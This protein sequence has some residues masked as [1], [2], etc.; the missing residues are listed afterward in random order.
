[1]DC[2]LPGFSLHGILQARTLEWVA[3]S[4]SIKLPGRLLL[5]MCCYYVISLALNRYS[6]FSL[7]IAGKMGLPSWLG[8]KESDCQ[9]RGHGSIPGRGR[10]HILR[11]NQALVPQLLRLCSE[12]QEPQ[13]L[14]PCALEPELQ[15]G[16]ATTMR[17][18]HTATSES[19]GSNKDPVQPN[20]NK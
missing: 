9:C 2:S 7:T 3:I 12:A 17:N 8:G 16:E 20:V 14:S 5:K 15:T 10:S 11:S 18:P 6:F 1:M 19:P 13:L 4:F